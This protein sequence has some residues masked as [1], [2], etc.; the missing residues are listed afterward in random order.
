MKILHKLPFYARGEFADTS[1]RSTMPKNIRHLLKGAGVKPF[2]SKE[3]DGTTVHKL[4][5]PEGH[6]F[7]LKRYPGPTWRRI[8]KRFVVGDWP[9]SMAS[10][11]Y[12]AA[13]LLQSKGIP[14]LNAVAWGERRVLGIWPTTNF[15]MSE[16]IQG[17]EVDD[18]IRQSAGADVRLRLLE[19]SASLSA[20]MHAANSF[21][22][23]RH[24]DLLCLNSQA[25]AGEAYQ[26]AIIDPDIKGKLLKPQAFSEK[27]A[28]EALSYS[29]YMMLR[30]RIQ[31]SNPQEYR[32]F[33]RSYQK[34][35]K[36]HGLELSKQ[37]GKLFRSHLN[38]QL[39]LHFKSP[40]LAENFP[41]VPR[42]LLL[43][44][45]FS[46]NFEDKKFENNTHKKLAD[47]RSSKPNFANRRQELTEDPEAAS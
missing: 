29:A 36:N 32:V 24:K 5:S 18:M 6:N 46:D 33:M 35:L 21:F 38:N 22:P 2:K 26:L 17:E 42:Q 19:A 7:Y 14:I 37:F 40:F 23:F 16:E 31:L 34:T 12:R 25:S 41:H 43:Q 27:L 47:S 30:S 20:K 8:V 4:T 11:E 39:E 3:R 10:D 45:N 13:K 28:C 9:A 44:L 1:T 15:I